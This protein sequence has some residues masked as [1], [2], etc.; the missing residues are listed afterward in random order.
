VSPDVKALLDRCIGVLLPYFRILDGDMHHAMR[1]ASMP[2][3]RYLF[4]G[5]DMSAAEQATARRLVAANAVNLAPK[6]HFVE[7]YPSAQ[8]AAQAL[9]LQVLAEQTLLEPHDAAQQDAA[10]VTR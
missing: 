5:D 9:A 8:V 4:Y 10:Q 2:D 7:F 1:N 6:R 3:M